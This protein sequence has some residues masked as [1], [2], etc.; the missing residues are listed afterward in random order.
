MRVGVLSDTHNSF[1]F[2]W[3]AIE[4]MSPVDMLLHA[5]DH[6]YDVFRIKL[7]ENVPVVAVAG[8]SDYGDQGNAEEVVELA[9]HRILLTHGHLY[10]VKF[11]C[12][13]LLYR[14][15]ELGVQAVVFG[16]TH[17]PVNTVE[18][19]IL[20]FNPGSISFPVGR[21]SPSF[22]ILHIDKE[23]KGEIFYL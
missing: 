2:A 1:E 22:G 7:P 9:G 4:E 5:G 19:G 13:K 3:R 10:Q 6:Y 17:M 18:K 8:N 15:G 16:H 12:D 23:I 21:S 14:A 11:T 20:L